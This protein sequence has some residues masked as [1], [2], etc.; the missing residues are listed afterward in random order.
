V[1][2]DRP[3]QP[4]PKLGS[5]PGSEPST[6]PGPSL[7]LGP[8]LELTPEQMEAMGRGVLD[9]VVAH[10][11]TLESQPSKG[12][13]AA[14]DLCRQLVEPL[15]PEAGGD[16]DDLV[17][18]LIDEWVGRSFTTPGP[19]YLA[20]VPGGGLYVSA[21]ADFISAATNRYTGVWEAAP[22]L[23]Q[24]EANVLS[25]FAH[26]MGMPDTTRGLLTT[27]GSLANF[28]A[29]VCAREK[30]LG[31]ALREG[32]LYT[33]SEAHLCVTKSARLAGILPDRVRLVPVDEHFRM[34]MDALEQAIATD[35]AAGLRP[36]LVVSSAGTTNT[37]AVDPLTS[38]SEL[39]K[40]HGL[41]HHIDGAYGAF[42]H[43]CPELQPL[44]AGLPAADSIALDPHKG[45][46]LPYG[47]GA[48]LVRD[49]EALRAAH[50]ATAD[51]LPEPPADGA[52][53]DPSQYGP[54][55]SRPFR[56]LRVWLP[57]MLHGAAAFRDA[58]LEKRQLALHAA[59]E[60]AAITG[61]IMDAEPQ[62]SLFA[63]HLSWPGATLREE[64]EATRELLEGVVARQRVMIT[65]CRAGGRFL[66]RVCVLSFRTHEDRIQACV[67]DIAS[68]A[69]AALLRR[70]VTG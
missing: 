51:Y 1:S 11:A 10:L 64:D 41:W 49:G 26:W 67:E 36:F 19:G 60:V 44:L 35:R 39:C 25:W 30:L 17:G 55:L 69:A 28:S 56:G 70:D 46:F 15:P 59:E 63:F 50:A 22:V 29:I 42:F 16:L 62:L 2:A 54:E 31:E 9:K 18:T 4:S 12:D 6:S 52:F 32:V 38:V 40:A 8:G 57:V 68:E 66:A 47:T 23:V 45:M 34:R 3:A 5:G 7:D 13:V 21:L 53:Y 24:L 33:S 58:L 43:M 20:F 48:L 14:A 61:L 27:G 65:G 37:G